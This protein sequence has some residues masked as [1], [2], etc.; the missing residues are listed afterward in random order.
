MNTVFGSIREEFAIAFTNIREAINK[1]PPP[2]DIL[3]RYS[4]LK[5]RIDHSNSI[6]DV[7]D[8]VNDDCT[9]I[10]ISCV[11]SVVKRFDIKEA[12]AHI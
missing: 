11:E 1:T 3:K 9:L 4:H 6:D 8:V 5:S 2:L 12:K 10:N 7:L